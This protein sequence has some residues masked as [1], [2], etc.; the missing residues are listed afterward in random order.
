MISNRV[1]NATVFKTRN[2]VAGLEGVWDAVRSKTAIE[3]DIYYLSN[4]QFL[5]GQ[6]IMQD[7]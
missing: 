7:M 2:N 6:F 4:K 1:G 5:N 3:Q